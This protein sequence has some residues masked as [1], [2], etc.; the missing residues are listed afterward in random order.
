MT[1]NLIL[2]AVITA[3]HGLKGEVKVK[4]FA[5]TPADF[6]R[7]GPLAAKSGEVFEITKARPAK[8][9]FICTLKN[10]ADRN[11]AEALRGTE[12]FVARE[13]LPKSSA[14]EFYLH[15]LMGREVVHADK[16]LG[17]VAGFQNFGAGDLMEL[18][19]GT[20]FPVAFIGEIG[21]TV[22]LNLPDFYLDA[23]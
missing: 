15:D 20:L 4:S 19:N 10:V 5:A 21:E 8:D 3:A 22:T 13:M 12:L 14:S 2:I 16:P 6:W 9:D 7:Y 23:E 1:E 18:D 11:R 17:M